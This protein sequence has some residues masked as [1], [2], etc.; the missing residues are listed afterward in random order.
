MY[1][2]K[3][4]ENS[5]QAMIIVILLVALVS[6]L[7]ITSINQISNQVKSTTNRNEYIQGKYI[8]ESG[9]ERTIKEACIKLNKSIDEAININEYSNNSYI[10]T[11]QESNI[12]NMK[13]ELLKAKQ[14]LE[15]ISDKVANDTIDLINN[16]INSIA[17]SDM[18]ISNI[19]SIINDELNLMDQSFIINDIKNNIYLSIG[20]LYKALEFAHLEKNK[21]VQPIELRDSIYWE[22]VN[23]NQ[24]TLNGFINGGEISNLLLNSNNAY[25]SKL[26]SIAGK[27]SWNTQASNL[28]KWGNDIKD[29]IDGEF[30]IKKSIWSY[31]DLLTNNMLSSQKV[32]LKLIEINNSID[33]LIQSIIELQIE[34][35][36]LAV[37]YPNVKSECQDVIKLY[38]TIK[39]E[40]IWVKKKLGLNASNS[41]SG[42]NENSTNNK[43]VLES[44]NNI[45]K[46]YS[47]SNKEYKYEIEYKNSNS[48]I[49]KQIEREV[50]INKDSNGNITSINEIEIDIISNA[51]KKNNIV[52]KKLVYRIKSKVIFKI[53][54]Q[55]NF[56]V[57][58]HI[59]SYEKI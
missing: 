9:I 1:K 15:Y 5:G 22:D 47:D 7:G 18:M 51:Y 31:H 35:I 48:E 54:I 58:Y 46:N 38:D 17:S 50:V 57:K 39:D 26:G 34:I 40:L 13:E 10:A 42:D 30:G 44:Y 55:E 28:H 29:G 14:Q 52:N 49:V 16:K 6:M 3:L 45:F 37:E 53:D 24:A 56:K 36:K 19:D 23:Y 4:K 59:E 21:N 12:Y 11:Y 20:Y 32:K 27:L 8:A 25:N 41:N 2:F 43:V 33:D